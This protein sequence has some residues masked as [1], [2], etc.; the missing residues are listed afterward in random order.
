MEQIQLDVLLEFL[1]PQAL[2]LLKTEEKT[3][4]IVLQDGLRDV[5]EADVQEIMEA[6][7]MERGQDSIVH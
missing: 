1:Y 2:D 6:V 5:S 7:I 3:V 4:P